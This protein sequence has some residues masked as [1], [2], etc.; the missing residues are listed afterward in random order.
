MDPTAALDEIIRLA[1]EA[2]KLWEG[3]TY[4]LL[5]QHM[6]S[7]V[8]EMEQLCSDLSGFLGEV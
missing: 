1:T 3:S 8:F 7:R 2:K 6:D 5:N 4:D